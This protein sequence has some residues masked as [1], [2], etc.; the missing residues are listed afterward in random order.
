MN[1]KIPILH[2]KTVYILLCVSLVFT[3]IQTVLAMKFFDPEVFL[4]AH[5]TLLGDIFNIALALFVIAVLV[6]FSVFKTDGHPDTL[7]KSSGVTGVFAA[8]S[9]ILLFFCGIYSLL[10]YTQEKSSLMYMT[11]KQDTFTKWAAVLGLVAFLYF[12]LA[13]FMP[14]KADKVKVWIGCVTIAWHIMQLLSVYFDM[15]NPLNNP[16]R[17]INEFALVGAMMYLTVEIRYLA[18][19]PK[20]GLYISTS[21]IAFTLLLASSVSNLALCFKTAVDGNCVYYI[22]QLLMAIYILSRLLSQLNHEEE[23]E[24]KEETVAN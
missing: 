17:L 18:K 3:V 20:K 24:S 8:A 14:N 13:A 23:A 19:I 10:T 7:A 11:E 12:M 5:G 1:K 9:G 22:Y 21:V 16:M 6:L 2:K 15:T 4:Y